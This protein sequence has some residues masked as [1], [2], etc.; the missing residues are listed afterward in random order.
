[1]RNRIE[2]DLHHTAEI[3]GFRYS[4]TKRRCCHDEI[5]DTIDHHDENLPKIHQDVCVSA[6]FRFW[7]HAILLARRRD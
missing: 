6:P 5:R 3:V 2:G 4:E 7:E 1:M